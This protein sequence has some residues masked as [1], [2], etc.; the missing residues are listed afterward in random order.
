MLEHGRVVASG[1]TATTLDQAIIQHPKE[2]G[3]ILNLVRFAEVRE[4]DG[5]WQGVLSGGGRIYLPA[6]PDATEHA[7]VTFYARDVVLSRH[8]VSG[9]SVR[10]QLAGIVADSIAMGGAVL[11]A[12]RLGDQQIW[13]RSRA[14]RSRSWRSSPGR[15]LFV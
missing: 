9:I 2:H 6:R 3:A 14:R 8:S 1:P 11:V 4:V 12:V 10:N 13:R 7:A 5:H 15:V